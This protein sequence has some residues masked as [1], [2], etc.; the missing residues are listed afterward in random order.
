MIKYMADI[1]IISN[2]TFSYSKF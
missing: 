1:R 2:R